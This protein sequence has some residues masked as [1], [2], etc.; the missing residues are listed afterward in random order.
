MTMHRSSLAIALTLALTTGRAPA[1]D[2]VTRTNGGKTTELAGRIEVEAEDGGVLLLT[3]DGTL[4]PLPKEEIAGRRKDE[5]PFG[6]LDREQLA[7]QVVGELPA[8]FKVHST[9][10]YL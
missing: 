6:P 8:G 10:H 9:K 1:I 2:F 4:W 3:R 5:A 7:K